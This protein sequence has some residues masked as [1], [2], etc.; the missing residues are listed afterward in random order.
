[1]K[2]L[3]LESPAKVNLM[4]S[5]H[6]PRSDGFH[7]LSSIMA[8]LRFGD[9]LQVGLSG[10]GEDQLHCEAAGVPL[11]DGNLILRA[12]RLFR[13][14]SGT[15]QTFDF[16]LEKRI[17]LGGGLGGG[18]SNAAVAL[19][20]M[21]ELT[22][23]KLAR[24]ELLQMAAELGSDCPFF[25]DAVSAR[26]SGRGE[27][28]EPLPLP[29]RER[30]RGQRIALFRPHFA[31]PTAWAYRRL[32]A[33]GP[34]T[35]E[36]A[37]VAHRRIEDFFRGGSLRDLLFNSFETVVGAKYLAI[38]CL[39]EAMRAS[40]HACLMSGSGSCCFAVLENGT[41]LAELKALCQDAWGSEAFFIES[42]LA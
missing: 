22:G 29:V 39:L 18:S 23:K 4:L 28:I 15:G 24:A 11:D 9:R 31:V 41:D 38:P 26:V 40:G 33:G 16:D 17:P 21:N 8:P 20:A 32:R 10:A 13:E 3:T 35:Y 1:M 6:G 25:I 42:W 14:H 36:D 27:M 12:A 30:L 5:V 19:K 34:A 7:D 37:G 2:S